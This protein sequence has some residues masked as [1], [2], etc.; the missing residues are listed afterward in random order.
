MQENWNTI[1]KKRGY[2]AITE[3]HM[4]ESDT[5]HTFLR[6]DKNG[7][8][9]SAKYGD[10]KE[11]ITHYRVVKQFEDFAMVRLVLDTGRTHQIRAH[12]TYHFCLLN[13]QKK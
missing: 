5:F 1:T 12:M 8:I 6:E 13:H 4:K 9:F 11:A 10:G 2:I 3:G 7:F